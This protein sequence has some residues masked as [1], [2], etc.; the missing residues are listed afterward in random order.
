MV[1]E[2]RIST[3]AQRARLGRLHLQPPNRPAARARPGVAYPRTDQSEVARTEYVTRLANLGLHCTFQNIEAFFERMKMGLNDAIR[4]QVTD[5][6]AHV[7]GPHP[8]VH[9][10]GPP[11]TVAPPI[12]CW[13]GK[14]CGGIN[15]RHVMHGCPRVNRGRLSMPILLERG[16]TGLQKLHIVN[17]I[18]TPAPPFQSL[19]FEDS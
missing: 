13:W 16:S 17:R 5:A 4:F 2:K 19:A 6:Y 7:Y 10:S 12:V 18:A 14:R 3:I 9:I 8:M 15:L 1:N 11:E